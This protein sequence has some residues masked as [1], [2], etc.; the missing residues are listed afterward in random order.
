MVRSRL[1]WFLVPVGFT[2]VYEAVT[3]ALWVPLDRA[4][5]TAKEGTL[6]IPYWEGQVFA[7]AAMRVLGAG[8]VCL[9]FFLLRPLGAWRTFLTGAL[10]GLVTSIADRCC[11]DWVNHFGTLAF[12]WH[13]SL[14]HS[15]RGFARFCYFAG[16]RL[17][18]LKARRFATRWR[19]ISI[20]LIETYFGEEKA[21]ACA[22]AVCDSYAESRTQLWACGGYP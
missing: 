10:F 17:G 18:G 7:F 6:S 12:R 15:S 2:V 19:N 22:N 13:S 20:T 8:L 1:S 21:H 16:L 5:L 9:F 3:W 11:W 4:A 14:F